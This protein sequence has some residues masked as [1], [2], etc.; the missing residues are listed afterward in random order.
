M[1]DSSNL[2]SDPGVSLCYRVQQWL[3]YSLLLLW[4]QGKATSLCAVLPRRALTCWYECLSTVRIMESICQ[5]FNGFSYLLLRS[6]IYRKIPSENMWTP[7]VPFSSSSFFFFLCPLQY[8]MFQQRT[9]LVGK[10]HCIT[11]AQ[12]CRYRNQLIHFS[13]I[14]GFLLPLDGFVL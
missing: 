6:G 4:Y 7:S 3:W 10:I 1:V 13:Y 8:D 9:I 5:L 14:N 2:K 12:E 11:V